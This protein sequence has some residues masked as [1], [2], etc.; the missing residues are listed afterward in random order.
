MNVLKPLFVMFLFIY[1]FNCPQN[2]FA[3]IFSDSDNTSY[4]VNNHGSGRDTGFTASLDFPDGGDISNYAN[5]VVF[6]FDEQ[7]DSVTTFSVTLTGHGDNSSQPID[8]FF[9]LGGS[10]EDWEFVG[11]YNVAQNINFTLSVDLVNQRLIYNGTDVGAVDYNMNRFIGIDSFL[12]AYGCHFWHDSTSVNVIAENLV[13][14]PE[15]ISFILFGF[16]LVGLLMKK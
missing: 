2:V 10:D 3:Y 6:E 5:G 15:P 7:L 12:V 13:I 11:S 9:N 14:I 8:I 4:W 1:A 16:S